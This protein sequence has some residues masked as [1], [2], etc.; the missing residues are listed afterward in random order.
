MNCKPGD[1]AIIIKSAAGNEGKIV[2]CLR[3]LP[4]CH[5]YDKTGKTFSEP[6]WEIDSKIKA[7]NGK[8]ITVATDSQLRPIRNNPGED[9]ALTW[10]GKPNE[11]KHPA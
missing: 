5:W 8:S 1:L 9:E 3:L 7:F 10:A 11:V 4:N 6:S 2:R